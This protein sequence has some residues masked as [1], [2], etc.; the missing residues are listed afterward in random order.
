MENQWIG[1]VKGPIHWSVSTMDFPM[2]FW[3]LPVSMVPN[4]AIHWGKRPRKPRFPTLVDWAVKNG[5]EVIRG[6]VR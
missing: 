5:A 6:K 1:L 2:D 3:T 4:K